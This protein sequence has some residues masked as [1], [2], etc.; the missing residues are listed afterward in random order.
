MSKTIKVLVNNNF[1]LDDDYITLDAHMRS[2]EQEEQNHSRIT[3]PQSTIP[4]NIFEESN[5]HLLNEERK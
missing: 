3:E 2:Q 1:D 5:P 4:D